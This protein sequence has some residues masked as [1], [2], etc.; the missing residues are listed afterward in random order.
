M[1][2]YITPAPGRWTPPQGNITNREDYKLDVKLHEYKQNQYVITIERFIPEYG[3][4]T[5]QYF[6]DP[7]E[8]VKI[9][10]ILSINSR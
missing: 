10:D 6:V 2:K 9:Q 5:Q 7:E 4:S 3:W 8:L 1:Q